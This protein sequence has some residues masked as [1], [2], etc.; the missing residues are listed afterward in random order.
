[1]LLE[2]KSSVQD[3]IQLENSAINFQGAFTF[4]VFQWHQT[5][6]NQKPNLANR[7][8]SAADLITICS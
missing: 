4:T 8:S 6:K 2:L 7:I 5:T 1:M 3:N